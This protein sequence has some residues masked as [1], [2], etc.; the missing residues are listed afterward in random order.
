[1]SMTDFVDKLLDNAIQDLKN[2]KEK[3]EKEVEFRL[4]IED[5]WITKYKELENK[6]IHSSHEIEQ[7]LGRALQYP[8]FKDDQFNFPGA[9]ENT[10]VCV[11]ASV[12]E[13]LAEEAADK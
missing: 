7:I 9:D 6:I 10:G 5:E 12:P 4:K 8:W 2:Y 11:G 3:Y 1:M 13:S